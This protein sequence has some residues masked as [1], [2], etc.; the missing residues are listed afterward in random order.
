LL[1]L[2]FVFC[3][4]VGSCPCAGFPLPFFYFNVF[5]IPLLA[6]A[7]KEVLLQRAGVIVRNCGLPV[8][9]EFLL[10]SISPPPKKDLDYDTGLDVVSF[11]L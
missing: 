4:A 9:S 10:P 2:A 5:C 6:E 3:E 11:L 8:S 7:V 1:I